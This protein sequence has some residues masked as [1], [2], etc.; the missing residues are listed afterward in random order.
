MVTAFQLV[1]PVQDEQPYYIFSDKLE[2]GNMTKR[3]ERKC[4]C[5]HEMW[6]VVDAKKKDAPKKL[7]LASRI[8]G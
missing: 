1:H 2:A 8:T 7:S 3:I 6:P 5:T 4:A